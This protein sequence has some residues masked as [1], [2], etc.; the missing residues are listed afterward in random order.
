[1]ATVAAAS[2][3]HEIVANTILGMGPG[4]RNLAENVR[5]G[6]TPN[7]MLGIAVAAV[8]VALSRPRYEGEE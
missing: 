8:N 6:G 7:S 3:A 1:M 2:P 4:Y 5:G